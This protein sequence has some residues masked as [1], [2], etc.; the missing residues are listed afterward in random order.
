MSVARKKAANDEKINIKKVTERSEEIVIALV[1]YAGAG[2]SSIAEKLIN[3]LDSQGYERPI[4]IKLSDQ[5]VEYYKAETVPKVEAAPNKGIS[6]FDRA[7]KLQNLG[8][9]LRQEKGELA[10]SA[11]AIK[12]IQE[13]RGE[14][15]AG[16]EKRAFIIDS[17]KHFEEI[18]LLRQV[19]GKS[20]YLLAI[21]CD[22]KAREKRLFGGKVSD[23]K[24][25][26]VAKKKVIKF[27]DRDEK[28]NENSAGQQVIKAFHHADYFL[29]NNEPNEE[30]ATADL[31][32]LIDL[33]LGSDLVRPTL[34]ETGMYFAHTAALRS[35]CLSR[36][37]GA[38]LQSIDGTIVA[39]GANDVP[40]VGGGI[41]GEDKEPE[42]RCFLW[43]K[44]LEDGTVFRGCHNYRMKKEL[45]LKI[46]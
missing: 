40:A 2:C 6:T 15:K 12:K 14:S 38:S 24:F 4:R 29:D 36:Q 25:A 39:T 9:R 34:R 3:L 16:R 11:L 33:I 43:D 35:S 19:Y 20:F 27:L 22:R 28:D 45:Q 32:R 37:V 42:H 5:I 41:C 10:L 30:S 7:E 21:H 8:D 18:V 44:K 26:G 13:E 1:G 17:I 31:Q 46:A 23:V